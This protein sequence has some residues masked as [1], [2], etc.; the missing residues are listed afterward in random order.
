MRNSGLKRVLSGC[1]L[2]SLAAVHGV[3]AEGDPLEA[4]INIALR[5]ASAVDTFRSF[6][7]LMSA[8]VLVD[9][10]VRGPVTVE[11]KNVRVRTLLDA[12]CESIGCRWSFEAG[13]PPVLKVTSQQHAKPKRDH[14]ASL[15]ER[16]DLKITGADSR[17]V[18]TTF[19]QIMSV[20]IEIEP[21]VSGPVTFD[22]QRTPVADALDAICQAVG[23]TWRLDEG[24]N[25]VLRVTAKPKRKGG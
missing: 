10:A 24:E 3:F 13:K 19:A 6:A 17:E 12:V 22:L 14:R 8:N 4:R 1:L 5:E 23:C 7:E 2:V 16:I 18:L 25:P 15:Q 11:L 21:E 20:G 9:P